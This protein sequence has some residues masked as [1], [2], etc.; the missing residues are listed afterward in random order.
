M[1]TLFSRGFRN[2]FRVALDPQ[3][4]KPLMVKFDLHQVA[5]LATSSTLTC[6]PAGLIDFTVAGKVCLPLG[7]TRFPADAAARR[8]PPCRSRRDARGRGCSRSRLQYRRGKTR[9]FSM[10]PWNRFTLPRKLYT[11]ALPDYGKASSA[12]PIC[13]IR[14]WFITTMRLASFE[15]LFLIMR[16]EDAGDF[17]L[18]V[19]PPQP[20]AQF[21][22]HL[23]VERA[24]RLVEQQHSRL[25]RERARECDALA[26][27]AGELR[28]IAIGRH[29]SCTSFNS[30]CTRR[31]I[32]AS[33]GRIRA[34]ARACRTRRSRTPSCGETA[35]NAERRSRPC[36]RAR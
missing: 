12:V 6:G 22:T 18:V 16:D 7:S 13:S 25:D 5:P 11:N 33:G 24:E 30:S 1:K 29:S 27:P 32:S 23:G 19:Q 26:L 28:G 21:L 20:S 35:R 36:A 3:L 31:A 14:P 4:A 34:D 8:A 2:D 9:P 10:R 15:R 17:D